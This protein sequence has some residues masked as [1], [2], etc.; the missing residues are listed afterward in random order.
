M[1]G[2]SP[3]RIDPGGGGSMT[4]GACWWRAGASAPCW[5]NMTK[6]S[7]LGPC[8]SDTGSRDVLRL[9]RIGISR[10]HG[11][12]HGSR[13]RG[14]LSGVGMESPRGGTAD[15]MDALL[16][17]LGQ[18]GVAAE[19]VVRVG[20]L[21]AFAYLVLLWLASALWAFVDMRRRTRS[22]A[23]PYATAGLVIVASPVLFPLRR[24][25]T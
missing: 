1:T 24:C 4:A 15:R 14:S 17:Q 25:S 13:I 23:M 16:N 19:P 6:A 5:L 18:G 12:G 11:C 3:P 2:P 10:S 22:A 20:L 8:P 7:V 21:V 9:S